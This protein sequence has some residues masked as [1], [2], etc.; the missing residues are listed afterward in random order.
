MQDG[1]RLI[2]VANIF[3]NGL[4]LP[5]VLYW[6]IALL[7]VVIYK[8]WSQANNTS[9][10]RL[11]K[12]ARI[13]WRIW[14]SVATILFVFGLARQ[15]QWGEQLISLCREV[16]KKQG[17][18][19]ERRLYQTEVIL[20]VAGGGA[21]WLCLFIWWLA[22]SVGR[23]AMVLIPVGILLIFSLVRTCSL[24][25]IDAALNLRFIGLSVNSWIE[26]TLLAAIG[27][28]ALFQIKRFIGKKST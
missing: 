6:G 4:S 8:Q 22:R 13:N 27:L 14:I 15:F 18:Y 1:S 26:F 23:N 12:Q 3:S 9:D 25:Q 10:M 28:A 5:V 19:K 21:V 7:Y 20:L 16:A 17:W 24:H 2:F 11:A